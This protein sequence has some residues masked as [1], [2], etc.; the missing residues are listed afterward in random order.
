MKYNQL[1]IK[2]EFISITI[3]KYFCDL[4]NSW[5]NLRKFK[6]QKISYI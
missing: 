6:N 2:I 4:K 3:S 5:I 1:N